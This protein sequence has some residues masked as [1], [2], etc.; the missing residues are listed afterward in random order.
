MFGDNMDWKI[1][2]MNLRVLSSWSAKTKKE[3][4]RR[5][6]RA[7]SSSMRSP[8]SRFCV[9]SNAPM[10]S[11]FSRLK[12]RKECDCRRL[13]KSIRFLNEFKLELEIQI[14]RKGKK[15]KN[16]TYPKEIKTRESIALRY[17]LSCSSSCAISL[18]DHILRRAI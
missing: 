6:L 8:L 2:T 4:L 7:L 13:M 3:R 14:L 16:C 5:Q 9:L 10:I 12:T 18:R 15:K 17:S 1:S 11:W